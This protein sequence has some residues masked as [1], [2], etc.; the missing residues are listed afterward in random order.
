MKPRMFLIAALLVA[1]VSPAR[2]DAPERTNAMVAMSDGVHLDASLYLPAGTA[3]DAD[4]PLIVRHHGGGSNK[5][6]PYDTGYAMKAVDAGFAVLMYSHRGHG[7]SEGLFD[8]FGA[9]TT[10]DFSQML[11]WVEATLG[12]RVDTGNVG[13]SGYS[14]GGGESLLPAGSDPRVKVAAVGQTFSDLNRALNPNDCYKMSWATGI[15]AAAYKSTASRTDDSIAGRWGASLYSDTEDVGVADV[16]P[17]ATDEMRAHSP[18]SVLPALIERRVPV[19]WA[20]AWEDQLFPGDHPA[21]ILEPLRA[22]GVPV[23]YWFSSGGHAAAGDFPAEVAAREAAMLDWLD[24]YLRGTDHGFTTTRPLVDY[25]MRVAPGR[26]GTWAPHTAT[27]YPIPSTPR[28]LYAAA[29]ATLR[30][31]VPAAGEIG[32]IVNDG[33]SANVGKDDIL[34]EVWGQT[35]GRAPGLGDALRGIPEDQNPTASVTY[36]SAPITTAFEATGAPRV[37]VRATTTARVVVQYSAKVWDVAPDG[38][39][40]LVSRGCVSDETPDGGVTSF[41]L[42]PNA[43]VFG[44]GHQ[45]VLTIAATDTPFFKPDVEPSVT[46]VIAGTA[47]ELPARA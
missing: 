23:H 22:S 35:A 1:A 24:Q 37:T 10:L 15:F 30:V 18:V 42:W 46:T 5:D 19:F 40:T 47:L 31:D 13:V 16:S 3:A 43:H 20:Q 33:A 21:E 39:A 6:N 4:L 36:T 28:A 45:I 34:N 32:T 7:N 14:Q 8:F 25:W 41:A 27:E 44:A 12:A 26:P 17:S 9:R 38:A 29:D 11:D 2:A